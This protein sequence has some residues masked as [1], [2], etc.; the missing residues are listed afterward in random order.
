METRDILKALNETNNIN[1]NTKE[2]LID[3]ITNENWNYYHNLT[4]F[5]KEDGL[6]DYKVDSDYYNKKLKLINRKP[7]S[8]KPCK[9]KHIVLKTNLGNLCEF[10][11]NKF[12]FYDIILNINNKNYTLYRW[13]STIILFPANINTDYLLLCSA[14]RKEFTTGCIDYKPYS[15]GFTSLETIKNLL[16]DDKMEI[17]GNITD[18]I[19]YNGNSTDTGIDY[20]KLV[21]LTN[22]EL[23]IKP[24]EGKMLVL[25][26]AVASREL[27]RR[28][29][30]YTDKNTLFTKDKI[31]IKST[32]YGEVINLPEPVEGTYY[33]VTLITALSCPNR[34]DLLVPDLNRSREYSDGLIKP[35]IN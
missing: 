9:N 33:I 2:D 20:E 24:F 35:I 26:P 17:N 6:T 23:I 25:Q 15:Y 22:K 10:N 21:N 4:E 19:S 7:N 1:K 16:G 28:V 32:I 34:K 13:F 30:E 14:S 31:R 5:L 11:D 8:A 3:E 27:P 18:Y 12:G 29:M